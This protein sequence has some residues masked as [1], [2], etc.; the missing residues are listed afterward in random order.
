MVPIYVVVDIENYEFLQ[1]CNRDTPFWEEKSDLNFW[2][3]Q[4]KAKEP[5]IFSLDT[6]WEAQY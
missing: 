3:L 5:E 2:K 6:M 4:K 1:D